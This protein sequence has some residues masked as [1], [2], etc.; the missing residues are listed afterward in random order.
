MAAIHRCRHRAPARIA[1]AKY[2]RSHTPTCGLAF[3][4]AP[5]SREKLLGEGRNAGDLCRTGRELS[6]LESKRPQLA[7][8]SRQW[9]ISS[10]HARRLR[11]CRRTRCHRCKAARGCRSGQGGKKIRQE[12]LFSFRRRC[13]PHPHVSHFRSTSRRLDEEPRPVVPI[14]HALSH[15]AC[16]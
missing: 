15:A 7:R 5:A 16:A 1:G 9:P 14:S 2:R 12:D 13:R 8:S 4:L 3:L 6:S 11:C 10:H